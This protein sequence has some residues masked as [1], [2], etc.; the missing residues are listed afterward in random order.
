M[1]LLLIVQDARYRSLI[2]HHV[3]CV[4]PEADLVMRSSRAPGVLPP[5][6]LAQGYDAVLVD[7]DWQGATADEI[8][9][10]KVAVNGLV[11]IHV[12]PDCCLQPGPIS[13]VFSGFAAA[14]ELSAPTPDRNPAADSP[15]VGLTPA[16]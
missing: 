13:T 10:G 3:T 4:W 2:R 7:Q 5:E 9:T 1:R 6:F 14:P 12:G 16:P 15:N 11:R 8:A